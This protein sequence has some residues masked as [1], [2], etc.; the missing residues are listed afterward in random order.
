ME[1]IK[2]RNDFPWSGGRRSRQKHQMVPSLPVWSTPEETALKK[3]SS[4]SPAKPLSKHQHKCPNPPAQKI[5]ILYLTNPSVLPR[6]SAAKFTPLAFSCGCNH[7]IYQSF[8]D[9]V[10]GQGRV[11]QEDKC[12]NLCSCSLFS[13]T[14]FQGGPCWKERFTPSCSRVDPQKCHP[15]QR[16][17]DSSWKAPEERVVRRHP[18][19][20]LPSLAGVTPD[21][22][23]DLTLPPLSNRPGGLKDFPI[24]QTWYSESFGKHG[25]KK[26]H[27]Y[28]FQGL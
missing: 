23:Q 16:P 13:V 2:R 6:T 4:P 11:N 26:T 8:S 21:S 15:S 20:Q 1:L 9:D 18:A 12:T 24:S 19:L 10:G 25:I 28:C 7:R 14:S 17:R 27:Y 5:T 3:D 22:S